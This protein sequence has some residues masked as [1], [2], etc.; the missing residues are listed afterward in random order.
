MEQTVITHRNIIS[1]GANPFLS[2]N[3]CMNMRRDVFQFICTC[4]CN[5]VIQLS[6][7]VRRNM[8]V[9]ANRQIK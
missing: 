5:W 2:P 8:G 6:V 3:I 4:T 9:R 1:G 7:D